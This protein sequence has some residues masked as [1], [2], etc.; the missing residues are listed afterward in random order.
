MVDS[1]QMSPQ[2]DCQY[3]ISY[4][5]SKIMNIGA[6]AHI[7]WWPS[8]TIVV[9]R[10]CADFSMFYLWFGLLEVLLGLWPPPPL[11]CCCCFPFINSN[12]S[13]CGRDCRCSL[14]CAGLVNCFRHNLQYEAFRSSA[15][16]VWCGDSVWWCP[17]SNSFVYCWAHTR[18]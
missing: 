11:R 8:G 17:N 10:R 6:S 13:L 7:R 14:S 1:Y 3:F 4:V 2:D 12:R 15:T 5:G 16:A 9:Q 18:Q